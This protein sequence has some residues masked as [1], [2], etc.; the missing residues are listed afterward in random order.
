MSNDLDPFYVGYHPVAPSAISRGVRVI[1][2]VLAALG[3]GFGVTLARSMNLE[4]PGV[5]EYGHLRTLHGEIR[6]FPFPS[7]LVPGPG[8]TDREAAYSR[9]LLVA[10]GKHGAQSLVAGLDGQGA[11]LKGVRIAGPDG[12][13]LEVV[14]NGVRVTPADSNV[15]LGVITPP[16]QD[17]GRMTLTG[18]IV[19]SKCW[20]GAMRP[21]AGNVHR[22]C[23]ARCLS[24]GIPPL[25]MT[26][27]SSGATVHYL[28]ADA[29][30]KPAIKQFADRAGWTMRITGRVFREGDMLVLWVTNMSP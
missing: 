7:L 15:R 16:T 21:A 10:E 1:V 29:D 22:G 28:L 4:A 14:G 19:D 13:M 2:V 6:E 23:A 5:F 11:E 9:Y 25:L 8:L 18:E 27:D 3:L 12:E 30:G 20:L 24:G 26:T 17:L